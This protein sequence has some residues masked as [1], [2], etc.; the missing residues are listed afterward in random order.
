[1]ST[2]F[3]LSELTKHSLN[4]IQV[5][6]IFFTKMLPSFQLEFEMEIDM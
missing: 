4:Y 5:S 2:Y 1:M 6:E 3:F